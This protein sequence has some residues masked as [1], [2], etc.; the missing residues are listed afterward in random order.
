MAEA[1]N[2]LE[3]VESVVEKA[4]SVLIEHREAETTL[5]QAIDSITN[6]IIVDNSDNISE[7]INASR[8]NMND[9]S[10]DDLTE[11]S[12]DENSERLCNYYIC[13]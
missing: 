1:E 2:Y 6:Q 9:I 13:F 8:S 3:K 10:S 7:N 5:E 12:S 4:A 11:L